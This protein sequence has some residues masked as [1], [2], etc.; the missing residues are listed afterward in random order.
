MKHK[1]LPAKA[2]SP[3]V[4]VLGLRENTELLP[5]VRNGCAARDH[6]EILSFFVGQILRDEMNPKRF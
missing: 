3:R 4:A 6:D 2:R 1:L 5:V